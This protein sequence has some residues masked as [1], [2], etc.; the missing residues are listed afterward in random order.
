MDISMYLQVASSRP[1][2]PVKYW[3][4]VLD[5]WANSRE[6]SLWTCD[7]LPYLSHY[8]AGPCGYCVLTYVRYLVDGKPNCF[9]E[10]SLR[11]HKKTPIGRMLFGFSLSTQRIRVPYLAYCS[12]YL[13]LALIA[14]DCSQ[15]LH[16][17]ETL[18][19][20]M[21]FMW[22]TLTGLMPLLCSGK[23]ELKLRCFLGPA[24]YGLD[25][26]TLVPTRWR[27]IIALLGRRSVQS[28]IQQHYRHEDTNP[29]SRLLTI[30]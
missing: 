2:L 23:I 28:S 22:E 27:S 26:F 8:P 24:H 13:L 1:S 14:S 12:C 10:G 16:M 29:L 6:S 5:P 15:R 4:K 30:K 9:V 3:L 25:W 11:I 21:I 17:H 19:F 7:W 18:E 20:A